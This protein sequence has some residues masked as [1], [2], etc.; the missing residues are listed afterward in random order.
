MDKNRI[1][2]DILFAT[3]F[4]KN[5]IENLLAFLNEESSIMQDLSVLNSVEKL[6]FLFSLITKLLN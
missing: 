1:S 3:L 5:K 6:P 4:K 2:S